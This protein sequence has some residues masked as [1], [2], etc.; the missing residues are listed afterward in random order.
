ME[1]KDGVGKE[2]QFLRKRCRA[3][4]RVV[5]GKEKIGQILM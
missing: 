5:M 2:G 3:I 4:R 1:G